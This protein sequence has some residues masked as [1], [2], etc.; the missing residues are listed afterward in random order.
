[1]SSSA[2]KV[3]LD[4]LAS[5]PVPVAIQRRILAWGTTHQDAEVL[6]RLAS[7]EGLDPDIENE[8]EGSSNLDVLLAWAARPGRSTKELTDRLLKEK[9]SSLLLGLA[10]RKDLTEEIYDQLA[11]NKSVNVRWALLGN[12]EV[13]M[14][15][16]EK[17]AKSLAPE[18]RKD[19]WGGR[20][21]LTDALGSNK[22]LWRIFLGHIN[23]NVLVVTALG[24]NMVDREIMENIVSYLERKS[25]GSSSSY[26]LTDIAESVSRRSEL[27]NDHAVRL[28]AALE[29]HYQKIKNNSYSYESRRILDI[30]GRL[31]AR[32]EGGITQLLDAVRDASDAE[33]LTNAVRHYEALSQTMRLDSSQLAKCVIAH[34]LVT[35]EL[36]SDHFRATDYDSWMTTVVNFDKLGRNDLLAAVA[37]QLGIDY[38][39]SM[40]GFREEV[41]RTVLEQAHK[42][43]DYD[44]LRVVST[45]LGT[46]IAPDVVELSKG[47]LLEYVPAA[48]L[49][50]SP[51]LA[52]LAMT[53]LDSEFGEDQPSWE[54]FE[55]L[56]GDF[57]G[58]LPELLSTVRSLLI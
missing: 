44:S 48:S 13:P 26:S 47:M 46:N 12:T 31:K 36:I 38:L 49:I 27:D 42:K 33:S 18:F 57:Q 3:Y 25:S 45:W 43:K 10:E 4:L 39:F 15:T 58:T 52:P 56:I 32:P 22:N 5:T 17:A 24:N 2:S 14:N 16:R 29:F 51:S 6:S 21:Q 53:M 54:I 11:D 23:T 20:R 8:L 41:C 1:M 7:I 37:T 40:L 34:P 28:I 19:N 55:T 50:G 35:P 9:R 30:I